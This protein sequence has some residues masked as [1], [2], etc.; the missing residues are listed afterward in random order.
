M[1]MKNKTKIR[2]EIDFRRMVWCL[3]LNRN[4]VQVQ[5]QIQEKKQLFYH[6]TGKTYSYRSKNVDINAGFCSVFIVFARIGD[7]KKHHRFVVRK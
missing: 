4:Q 3:L 7:D 5:M 6:K 1:V 2:T